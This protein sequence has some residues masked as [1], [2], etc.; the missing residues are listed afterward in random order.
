MRVS[1]GLEAMSGFK[2][3]G[4]EARLYLMMKRAWF[5]LLN[6]LIMMILDVFWIRFD[7][8]RIFDGKWLHYTSSKTYFSELL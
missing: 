4:K 3:D 1:G 8:N 2:K 7:G 6:V 5:Y